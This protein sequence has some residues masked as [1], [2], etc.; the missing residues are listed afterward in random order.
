MVVH[1]H[2]T[3]LRAAKARFKPPEGP[4]CFTT[5]ARR[6]KKQRIPSP[7]L[8]DSVVK[9]LNDRIEFRR[10]HYDPSHKRSWEGHDFSR[11]AKGRINIGL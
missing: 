2:V 9:I 5:E 10:G 6:E 8:C 3:S 1:V 7:C 4:E 11:A